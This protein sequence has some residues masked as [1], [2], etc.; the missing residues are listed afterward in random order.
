MVVHRIWGRFNISLPK[1]LA[2]FLTFNFV[3]FAW[4]FFR[5]K[6]WDDALKVVKGMLG[7]NGVVLSKNLA[8]PLAFLTTWGVEFG[9]WM[10]N[11]QGSMK[12]IWAIIIMVVIAVWWKNSNDMAEKFEPSW[13]SCSFIIAITTYSMLSAGNV[14]EFLYFN[15]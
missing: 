13:K 12:T 5:A 4:I 14:K 1:A 15:F 9:N 2:W 11:I 7:L 10:G 3:N 8:A 6:N